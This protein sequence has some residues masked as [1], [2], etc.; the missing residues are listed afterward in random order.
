MPNDPLIV[1]VK[2]DDDSFD[3]FNNLRQA[4][5]PAER[6]QPSA[7]ITLFHRLPG[8]RLEEIEDF[9]K[10]VAS[11]QYEFPLTFP[12][13][14]ILGEG[15]AVEV[16]ST[17]LNSLRIKLANQWS[18]CLEA[19]DREKFAPHITIHNKTGPEAA[20][21]WFDELRENWE[22]RRGAARGLQLWHYRNG[23]WRIANEF[24]FYKTQDY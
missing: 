13:V 17:E 10:T 12:A 14:R 21:L 9:L 7:Q 24:A 20:R 22:R 1:T 5:F 23:P 8:E 11:R 18:D 16:E 19:P 15:M 4:H 6:N 2:I 3:Y